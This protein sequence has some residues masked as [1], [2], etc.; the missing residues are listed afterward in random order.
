MNPSFP[1]LFLFLTSLSCYSPLSMLCHFIPAPL[2]LGCCNAYCITLPIF[3]RHTQLGG[4]GTGETRSKTD[5]WILSRDLWSSWRCA[6]LWFYFKAVAHPGKYWKAKCVSHCV[7]FL[8]SLL[9][10]C[11]PR[12]VEYSLD[13][14]N[15]NLSAI[16]TV[17]VLRPLKAINRVPSK[18]V[19]KFLTV[20]L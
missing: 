10:L 8:S 5:Q 17:R 20:Y 16:R 1:V 3:S 6:N 14:Q 9:S 18:N 19:F 7:F 2:S 15:I 12:M 11:L 13:L 4:W